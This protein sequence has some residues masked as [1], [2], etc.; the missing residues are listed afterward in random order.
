PEHWSDITSL[1]LVIEV[2]SPRSARYDRSVKRFCYQRA[3]VPDYWTVDLDARLVER[4]TPADTRPEIVTS[5][6]R[7]QPDGA[8]VGLD[9]DLGRVP[10][11]DRGIGN[12]SGR[13]SS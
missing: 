5:A 13:E 7:W 11:G 8:P 1:L 9:I 6:F 12:T 10:G 4:W 3:G 2:V